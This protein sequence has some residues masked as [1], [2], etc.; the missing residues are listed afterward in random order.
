MPSLKQEL[1]RLLKPS[2]AEQPYHHRSHIVI[3]R[4]D[5][6]SEPEHVMILEKQVE[7]AFAFL[8]SL[9]I[10]SIDIFELGKIAMSH[11]KEE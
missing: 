6:D 4:E 3:F 9:G 11:R 10:H 8:D 1:R 2:S 5:K 7:I